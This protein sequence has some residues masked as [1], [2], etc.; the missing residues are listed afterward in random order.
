MKTALYLIMSLSF[1]LRMENVS[2]IFVEKIK[3]HISVFVYDLLMIRN[4]LKMIKIDRN[5]SE[6]RKMVCKTYNFNLS[7]LVGFII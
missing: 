4:S 6:L 3:T 2:D 1:R 5:M 7:A